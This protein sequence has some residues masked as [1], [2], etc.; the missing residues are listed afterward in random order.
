[1][2]TL[3]SVTLLA[4]VVA[5]ALIELVGCIAIVRNRNGGR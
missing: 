1:M 2:Y 3:S 5:I 4:V